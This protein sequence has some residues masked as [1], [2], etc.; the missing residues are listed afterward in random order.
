M[1]YNDYFKSVLLE[2]F[3]PSASPTTPAGTP[4]RPRHEDASGAMNS[5]LDKD[6]NPDEF[7]RD[8]I[9]QT[10][11]AVQEHFNTKMTEFA[12]TLSPEAVKSM[13]LGELRESI[14]DVYKFVNKIQIYSKGKIEQIS[15][16]PYAIMA[17]FLASDP[18]RM[19]AFAD[20]HG[21]LD[22]F[23]GAI[24]ELESQ[25]GSLKG[26]I[27]DFVSEVEEIDAEDAAYDI[28]KGQS[29]QQSSMGGAGGSAGSSGGGPVSGPSAGVPSVS[30]PPRPGM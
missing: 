4:K 26:Q 3:E 29:A 17:A 16:D 8:G 22:E 12:N 24:Q 10:F 6:T 23:Q 20:L 9:Q 13:P 5:I 19:A 1:T 28:R 27:D 18:T 30:G 11:D 25:L 15:Q 14:G 21:N 2:A 7:L